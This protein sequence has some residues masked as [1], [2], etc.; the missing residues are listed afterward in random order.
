MASAF[1][2]ASTDRSPGTAWR[3]NA[4]SPTRLKAGQGKRL[5]HGFTLLEILL[6]IALMGLLAAVLVTGSVNLLSEKP[7]TPEAVFWQAVQQS[8]AL[9][10]TI[11][12]EVRL[13]FD[14]KLQ[15]F[16][17]D[18]GA[19]P[20]TLP[21]PAVRELT[22]DFLSAQAGLSSVLIGGELVDTKTVS[23]VTFYPDGTCSPFRAQF[24]SGGAARV[25]SI[26]PWTCAQVLPRVE[27]TP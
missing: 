25:L 5:E 18:D 12:R 11:E 16:V 23:A 22:V 13:S 2:N 15:A 27:G 14:P 10:L 6:A 20:Q 8:R 21:V 24:R 3:W 7:A 4:L 19:S 17:L 26:D 9:A 1:A